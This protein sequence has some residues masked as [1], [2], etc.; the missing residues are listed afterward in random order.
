MGMH[1]VSMAVPEAP[2]PFRAAVTSW[3]GHEPVFSGSVTS[4]RA[5]AAAGVMSNLMLSCSV[6]TVETK[7]TAI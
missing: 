7:T 4:T 6:S 1:Y 3:S 2:S 5:A